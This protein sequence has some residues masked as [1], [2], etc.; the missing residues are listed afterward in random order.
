MVTIKIKGVAREYP[1]G[2]RYEEIA[3]EYQKEYQ[4]MIALVTENGKIRELIKP[5]NRDCELT[6]LTIRDGIG[7]KSYVR[8]ALMTLVKAVRDVLGEKG[9]EV[10]VE[11]VVGQGY[12]CNVRM[13]EKLTEEMVAR[14]R[15]RMKELVEADLPITKKSYPKDDAMQIFR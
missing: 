8:T 11:F 9:K 3:R 6:F 1:K 14:I 10:K 4:D 5:A 12:Y 7:H 15:Q 2:T 13:E